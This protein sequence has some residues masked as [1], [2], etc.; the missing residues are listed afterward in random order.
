MSIRAKTFVDDRKSLG[1]FVPMKFLF[2][3]IKDG[4][5]AKWGSENH[6]AGSNLIWEII[7]LH[8]TTTFVD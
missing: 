6:F 7:K 8:F 3:E 5:V 4:P 1:F 2:E